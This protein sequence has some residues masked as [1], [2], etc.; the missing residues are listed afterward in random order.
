MKRFNAL[1]LETYIIS[2]FLNLMR[3]Y[4]IK[5]MKYDM[6]VIQDQSEI[7]LLVQ[8]LVDDYKDDIKSHVSSNSQLLDIT[9]DFEI[10][11]ETFRITFNVPQYWYWAENGRRPGKQPP[12]QNIIDWI[13]IKRIVPKSI[14]G[15]V[16]TTKQ[17]AFVIARSIGKK[18]TK[19]L[20]IFKRFI[21]SPETDAIL[22]QIKQTI[23]NDTINKEI[24]D[25]N[26]ELISHFQK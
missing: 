17:L 22:K 11:G 24:E 13:S 19:G 20:G 16:P 8:K 6:L 18:G 7:N 14:N 9:A 21:V 23:A 3:L 12:I 4:R 1:K 5:I 26:N 2:R 10:Q 25:F 15:K